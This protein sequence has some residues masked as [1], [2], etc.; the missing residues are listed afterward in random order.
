MPAFTRARVLIVAHKT[1]DSDELA[2]AVAARASESACSFTLMVPA[3]PRGLRRVGAPQD[4]DYQGAERRLSRALPLLSQAAGAEVVGIVGSH[5]PFA[6]VKDAM[7]LLG[8]DEVIVSM[9]PAA[10]SRWQREEL[11]RKIRGLGVAVTEVFAADS[12]IEPVPA[13]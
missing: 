10:R 6:A 9:L 11:P 13:A 2:E 4:Y 12:G 1:A 8:F 5:E 3:M 7:K